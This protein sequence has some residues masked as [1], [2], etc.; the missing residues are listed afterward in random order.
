MQVRSLPYTHT[1]LLSPF[2]TTAPLSPQNFNLSPSYTHPSTYI[3]ITPILRRGGGK[4]C[5]G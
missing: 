3:I 5:E 1:C 2:P 4:R